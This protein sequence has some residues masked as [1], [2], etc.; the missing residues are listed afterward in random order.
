MRA[1]AERSRRFRL[2]AVLATRNPLRPSECMMSDM[3][4]VGY[5]KGSPPEID[6][7]SYLVDLRRPLPTPRARDLLV[8]VEAISVN[9]VDTKIRM[10]VEP[11]AGEANVLGWDVAGVVQGVGSEATLFAPGDRVWYAGAIDRPGCN[12]EYHAVDERIVGA[13]PLSLDF[14]DAAAL[15]LTSITAWELLFDRLG[16]TRETTGTLLVIGGAGGV[17]SIL[18]QLARKLTS[19]RVVATASREESQRWARICGAHDVIDHRNSIAT[20][21]RDLG[22]PQ[23]DYIASLTHTHEH[24][25]ELV[26]VIAP[27]GHLALIDDPKALDIMP[28]KRKS[29]AVHWELMFTRSLFETADMIEQH[30]LL[31]RVAELVDD[32]TLKTSKR[33]HFGSICAENLIRAH[34]QILSG[35]TIGKIVLTGFD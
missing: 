24:L 21:L 23:V 29:V 34:S 15:P 11:P 22:S 6:S 10:R 7:P 19:L 14:A 17:G 9:P 25:A 27:Q 8:R 3:K 13:M 16:V 18:V 20:Q 5:E 33:E 35:R 26:E 28:F 12:A 30:R 31:N 2:F 1:L 32:G 4:I